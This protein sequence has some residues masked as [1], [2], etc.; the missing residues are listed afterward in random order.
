MNDLTERY[1]IKTA[2]AWILGHARRTGIPA[3]LEA[4]LQKTADECSEEELFEIV[5]AGQ[6]AELRLYPFKSGTMTLARTK[7]TLGFLHSISFETM[8]DVGSGRG[9]FLIP[10]MKEF[11][12]VEVTSLDLL[13]KRVVFLNEL[14]DGGFRQ[15]HAE[16]MDV[17][18]QPFP[19]GSFDVVTLL[20]VLEHIPEVDKAVAAA[21]QMAR[22]YVVVTVPSK[23]DS[24]PEHIHLLTKDRLTKLFGDAG[25]TRL[26]FDGV[27]GHL[28]MVAAKQS[29]GDR[30]GLIDDK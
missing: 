10:F 1:D 19:D 20:E 12:W 30:H 16:R 21:V 18:G 28:F 23:P 17:C 26:H 29:A 8:L 22:Q 25:C 5:S 3:L 9:V 7:R 13:E 15:L 24:N 2:A 6:A 11:P 27:E 4:L 14:A